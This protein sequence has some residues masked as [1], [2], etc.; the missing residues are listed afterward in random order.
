[1][2]GQ[3]QAANEVE[4][5]LPPPELPTDKPKP[6]AQDKKTERQAAQPP[7]DDAEKQARSANQPELQA[8]DQARAEI[9]DAPP[10]NRAEEGSAEE[11]R[12]QQPQG[13]YRVQLGSLR[14][15]SL[16]RTEWQRLRKRYAESLG[17]LELSLQE[18][19]LGER[20]TFFRVQAGPLTDAEAK[21]V[22]RA[23]R[24]TNPGGCL[25][26]EP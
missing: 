14:T 4:K 22:C 10:S 16:A 24:P 6:A 12:A 5:L 26:V 23:I 18:V 13:A 20:G 7:T 9:P 3:G 21:A 15:Q 11:T 17:G 2:P 25:I 19:D 1:M 8:K